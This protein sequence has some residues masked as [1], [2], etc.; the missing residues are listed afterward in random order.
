MKDRRNDFLYNELVPIRRNS[1]I[2]HMMKLEI[3]RILGRIH[4]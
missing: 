1:E 3:F 2:I 4:K